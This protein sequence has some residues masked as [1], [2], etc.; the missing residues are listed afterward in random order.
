M[1]SNTTC[2]A[3]FCPSQF[4]PFHWSHCLLRFCKFKRLTSHQT[5]PSFFLLSVQLCG[6]G[7]VG[8]QSLLFNKEMSSMK[9]YLSTHF[10]RNLE[11]ILKCT[12]SKLCAGRCS[13][14]SPL[15][16]RLSHWGRCKAETISL[17]TRPSLW[18]SHMV[19]I[20]WKLTPALPRPRPQG[21]T[22][23]H[24]Q[25]R[26]WSSFRTRTRPFYPH[27]FIRCCW[28]KHSRD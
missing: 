5:V 7:E 4:R 23:S 1:Y 8:Y 11:T 2:L 6:T 17:S 15:R 26:G 25:F 20:C 21:V 16:A 22:F 18:T 13:A 28:E 27:P 14:R 9:N 24:T 12:L 19:V 3:V 10:K